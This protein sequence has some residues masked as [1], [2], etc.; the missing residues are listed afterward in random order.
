MSLPGLIL[1]RVEWYVRLP[2]LQFGGNPPWFWGDLSPFGF[3]ENR[4]DLGEKPNDHCS[5]SY[6]TDPLE[7]LSYLCH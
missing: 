4:P 2:P 6:Y 5:L 3:G 1:Y 7:R